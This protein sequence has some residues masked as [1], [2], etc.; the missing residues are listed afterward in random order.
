[1][2]RIPEPELMEVEDQ[3]RA[4]AEADFEEPHSRF[5]TLLKESFP[6]LNISG[7]VLDLGCGPG[8]ISMRV[9]R[10]FPACSVLGI[11]G[12]QAMLERGREILRRSGALE[13]RV[14]LAQVMLPADGVPAGDYEIIISNSLLHHLADP[15]VLWNAIRE[16]GAS[17]T[18]VFVMDLMRPVS[19][20]EA[21]K[22]VEAYTVGEP[23]I[24]K[25]DFHAS[26]LAAYRIDEVREQLRGAGLECLNL[27]SVS[28]RHL[29]VWG[30]LP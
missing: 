11:D 28:D 14:E 8:D 23:E 20:T 19:I 2:E 3:A 15:Q 17:G 9:A 27:S 1:M 30:R 12:S 4:Y 26:L 13:S 24:L 16:A 21:K 22:I 10:A 25:K 18:P 5:L 6:Q 29:L 7:R